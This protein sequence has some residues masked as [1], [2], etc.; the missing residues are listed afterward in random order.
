MAISAEEILEQTT[1][2]LYDPVV[3][4]VSYTKLVYFS[5]HSIPTS[6]SV[7]KLNDIS[8]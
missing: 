1:I 6:E 8:S 3:Y 2:P 4:I 5:N 7:K